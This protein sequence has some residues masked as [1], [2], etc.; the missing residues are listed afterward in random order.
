MAQNSYIEVDPRRL[1]GYLGFAKAIDLFIALLLS[2][3]L[4]PGNNSGVV[5][6]SLSD[7]L[8]QGESVG[9]NFLGFKVISIVDG[10]TC[11]FKQSAIRNLPLALPLF[12]SII[13]LCGWIL[14]ILIGLPAVGLELY[15][16]MRLESS[17]RLGDVDADTTIVNI[18]EEPDF[19]GATGSWFSKNQ[20]MS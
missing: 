10:S 17:H 18:K 15:L 19:V 2:I 3:F 11:T 12:L 9:K 20:K 1:Q 14:T 13:P 4:S 7:G 6:L 5:Y 16:M 8:Q